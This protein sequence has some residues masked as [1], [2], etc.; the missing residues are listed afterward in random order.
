[1]TAIP[2]YRPAPSFFQWVETRR[3]I[4]SLAGI[5][6]LWLVLSVLTSRFSL[7]SLSGVAASAAFLLFPS[8]GQMIVV[9]TGRGNIDLS[10]P[11]VITLSAFLSVNIVDGS[12]ARLALGLGAVAAV[13]LGVG[14]VNAFLVLALRIPAMIATLA[15]GY[16]LATA[17]LLANRSFSTYRVSPALAW[18]TTGKV[19]GVPVIVLAALAA[20]ALAAFVLSRTVFGRAL[21]AV[22]QNRRAAELA[23]VP[24]SRVIAI[25]FLASGVAAGLTG[26]LLSARAG[27]AFLDMGSPFLLQSVGAVVLGGTLIFGGCATAFG[28]LCG[29]VLLVLIVTTMQIAGLPGGTQEIIQGA[30]IIAVLA[31]AGVAGRENRR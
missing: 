11:S 5:V 2:G 21:S 19:A 4:W 3:W 26:A 20:T 22:G 10:I 1:M 16:I 12:D 18:F 25:A 7:Q 13:G 29:S 17:T 8:L 14:A 27:G 9:T 23:G 31:L 24:A 6:I 28:T 15:T 30:V